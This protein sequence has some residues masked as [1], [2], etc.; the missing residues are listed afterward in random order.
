MGKK[1]LDY[2]LIPDASSKWKKQRK[3]RAQQELKNRIVENILI[4]KGKDSEEDILYLGKILKKGDRIGFDTFPFHYK[5][6]RELIKKAKKQGKFPKGIKIENIKTSQE[7]KS[8]V[9]GLLG[10]LEE[11]VKKRKLD[12]VSNRHEFFLTKVK[13]LVKKVLTWIV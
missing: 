3:K 1:K 8:F 4:L 11:C 6:Y 7:P 13:N 5:E 12:Y 9:Y 10:W 2:L